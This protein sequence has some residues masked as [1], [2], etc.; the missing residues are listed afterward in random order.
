VSHVC[1]IR[2][3]VYVW[4]AA[5]AASSCGLCPPIS[6]KPRPGRLILRPGRPDK[7]AVET[8]SGGESARAAYHCAVFSAMLSPAKLAG[9]PA[10]L[11][12]VSGSNSGP[13]ILCDDFRGF[14][15]PQQAAFQFVIHWPSYILG[16]T[17]STY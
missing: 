14:P 8:Q 4:T 5:I 9:S 16:N 1:S 10:S 15:Q 11:S 17:A 6:N 7:A 13:A 2:G 12:D 3:T